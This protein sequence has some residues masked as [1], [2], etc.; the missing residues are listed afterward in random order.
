MELFSF[1]GI[2]NEWTDVTNE[3]I[4]TYSI[5]T[6]QANILMSKIHNTKQRMPIIL[7]KE[8]EQHWLKG[9]NYE[10]FK[11][12]YSCDLV[13]TSLSNDFTSQLGLF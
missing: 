2:Y 3:K 7:K 1:A 13:A 11:F 8:D 4:N 12:P 5:I 6:T 10:D 9:E